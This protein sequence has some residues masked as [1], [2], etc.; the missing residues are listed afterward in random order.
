MPQTAPSIAAGLHTITPYRKRLRQMLRNR[1]WLAANIEALCQQ[2]TD[3]WVV[4]D[5]QAVKGAGPTPEAA[6]A[7]SGPVDESIALI[8]MLPRRIPQPI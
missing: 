1:A 7:A 3:Q 8:L 2:Y 5:D 4:I 6:T